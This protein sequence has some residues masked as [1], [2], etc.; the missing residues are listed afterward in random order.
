MNSDS[1]HVWSAGERRGETP[2]ILVVAEMS[3][4]G[5]H[6]PPI[7]HYEDKIYQFCSNEAMQD[8]MIGEYSGHAKYVE[9]IKS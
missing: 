6:W 8:W 2:Y 7:I 1:Y 4:M 3:A 5:M 9:R